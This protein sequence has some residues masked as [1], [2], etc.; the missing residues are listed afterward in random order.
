[1]YKDT[2]RTQ[3][4]TMKSKMMS[5]NSLVLN[6]ENPRIIKEAKFNKLVK[7]LTE[8][9]QMLELR[10]VVVDEEMVVLGGNMRLRA[11]MHLGFKEVPVVVAT[12]LTEEQKNEFIVKDNVSFGEWDWDML[13]DTWDQEALIEWGFEAYNFGASSNILNSFGDEGVTP[14]SNEASA[15]KITDEGYVR[16]EIVIKEEDKKYLVSLL[17]NFARSENLSLGDAFMTI[18]KSFKHD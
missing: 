2:K 4:N 6:N 9:P 18:I 7:S 10:P 14:P 8:F 15:P 5:V 12:G 16:W 13:A 1:M 17:G 3:K 11:A